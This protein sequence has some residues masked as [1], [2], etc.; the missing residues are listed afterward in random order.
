MISSFVIAQRIL[1]KIHEHAPDWPIAIVRLKIDFATLKKV[2]VTLKNDLCNH[3]VDILRMANCFYR[4]H[5]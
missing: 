1:G 2:L 3:P 4:A 5:K